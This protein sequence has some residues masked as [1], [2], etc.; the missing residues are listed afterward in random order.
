MAVYMEVADDGTVIEVAEGCGIFFSEGALGAS[1][2]DGQRVALAVEGTHEVVVAAARHAGNLDVGIQFH[3]LADEA[4]PGV[5]VLEAVAEVVP[6]LCAADDI[7][8]LFCALARPGL[9]VVHYVDVDLY[10]VSSI[11][12]FPIISF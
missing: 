6:V 1:V 9:N 7:G 11:I 3:V 12:R 2:G 5:V 4:V 10:I 8:I